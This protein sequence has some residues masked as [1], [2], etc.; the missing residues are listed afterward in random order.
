ML[1][2]VFLVDVLDHL[3]P[4][5]GGE[6][7]VD[8]R[9]RRPALVDE[10]LE[11]QLVADRVDARDPEHV[12]DDRVRRAPP[13]LRRD[14]ARLRE[15]HQ[16]PADQ[17][18]LGQ[19]GL[20]DH[21]QL[22][23]QLP[24]DGRRHRVIA[25]FRALPA[26]RHQVAERGLAPRHVEAREA[27][28]LEGELHPAPRGDLRRRRDPRPPGPREHRVRVGGRRL[29]RRQREQVG[30][31]LEIRL[32]V[33]S[34]EVPQLGQRP[35]VVDRGQH[36]V[37]LAALGPVVVDVVGHDHR[38]PQLLGQARRL[39]DEPVVVGQEVV[40]QLEHEAA[41]RGRLASQARR[42]VPEQRR[43]SLRHRPGP[44]PVAGPQPPRQLALAAAGQ[45]DQPLRVLRQQRLGELRDGLR[46]GEVRPR[47]QPAQA[48]PARRVPGEQQEVRPALRLADSPVVLLHD[49]AMTRQPGAGRAGPG[50]PSPVDRRRLG[51]HRWAASRPPGT[52]RRDH[53]PRRVRRRGVDELDLDPDH[54]TQ[55]RRL[56]GGREADRAVQALVVRDGEAGEA[57]LHGP[58]DEV[59]RGRGPV[60]EREVAVAV[61]LGV[62][63]MGH[64]TGLRGAGRQDRTDV[65][66]RVSSPDAGM[67]SIS[68]PAGRN[69]TGGSARLMPVIAD[70]TRHPG[71][72]LALELLVRAAAIAAATTVI[73][74]LLPAI[75]RAVG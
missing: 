5:L 50:G 74:G 46:P 39:R 56:R 67:A 64:A 69:R 15:P 22:V 66:N 16:V 4:P 8:V 27:V 13:P 26:Q 9:V 11:Q 41:P 44:L 18:E 24:H 14:V 40:G 51:D 43:V 20:L 35:A 23:R 19:P 72:R 48:P 52:P 47:H 7:D 17:E 49:L 70:P 29:P 57:E 61:Q 31:A 12:G 1:G 73:L 63:G 71:R 30:R 28:A 3:L 58:R 2:P 25:P 65:L 38:Q 54:G 42:P 60:E 55:P 53:D 6:V 21:V 75:A 34:P 10:P 45:R 36:V 68:L 32:P 33:R 62:G 37:E 59:V